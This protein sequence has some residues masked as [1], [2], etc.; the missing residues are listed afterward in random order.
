MLLALE[1][2]I[3]ELHTGRHQ[4][5]AAKKVITRNLIFWG[6]R[7]SQPKLF[8]LNDWQAEWDHIYE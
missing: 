4:K 7:V 5:N 8:S 6:L 3:F 1:R 2:L